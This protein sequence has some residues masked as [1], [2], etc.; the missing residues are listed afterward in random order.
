MSSS[1]KDALR[2][3]KTRSAAEDDGCIRIIFLAAADQLGSV[4]A[5][6]FPHCS[7]SNSLSISAA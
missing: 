3:E 7:W 1:P 6:S 4:V 5:S 2:S